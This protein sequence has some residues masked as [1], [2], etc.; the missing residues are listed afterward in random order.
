MAAKW[1][2][3]CRPTPAFRWFLQPV[4]PVWAKSRGA[5]VGARLGRALLNGRQSTP[6]ST[7]AISRVIKALR[8]AVWN[9]WTDPGISSTW[10]V[11][12]PALCKVVELD[13]VPGGAFTTWISEGDGDFAPH[14][15]R[16]FLDVEDRRRL[17]FTNA[18]TGGWRPAEQPFMTAII[19]LTDHPDGTD[20]AAHAMHKSPADRA[21]HAEL[22]LLRRLGHGHR[23]ARHCRR[24]AGIAAPVLAPPAAGT[25]AG[26]GSLD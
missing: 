4:L 23:P 7:S 25:F 11:P 6:I 14:L 21:M 16:L 5:T 22:G 8:Q 17:V 12:A 19:T 1:A 10:R 3:G 9:A 2:N 24:E 18:L 15:Q 13:L 20:Y 26:K